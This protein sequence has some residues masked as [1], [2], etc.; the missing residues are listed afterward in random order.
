MSSAFLK[1][2]LFSL[3]FPGFFDDFFQLNEERED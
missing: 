3:D 2:L 1:K